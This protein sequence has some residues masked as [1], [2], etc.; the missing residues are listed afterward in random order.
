VKR[1]LVVL[2]LTAT[3]HAQPT[4]DPNEGW[5]TD[6]EMRNVERARL[7]ANRRV[8]ESMRGLEEFERARKQ[9]NLEFAESTRKMDEDFDRTRN[10]MFLVFGAVVIAML[11]AVA[12]SAGRRRRRRE[13]VSAIEPVI[14]RAS[15]EPAATGN[16]DVT[17]LRFGVDATPGKFVSSELE[18]LTKQLDAT[19]ED[20]RSKLVRE[21]G[22]ALR[23][24]RAGWIYGGAVNEPMRSLGEAK[25]VFAKH[26]DDARLRGESTG[27]A[28]IVVIT[29]V[30]VARGEL[31]TVD[32]IDAEHL[33]RALEAAAYRDAADIIDI[34]VVA[35]RCASAHELEAQYP[36]PHLVPLIVVGIDKTFCTYCG[37]PIPADLVGCPHC[38]APARK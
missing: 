16:F 12:I 36:R 4:W 30:V 33:R 5:V 10:H 8:E 27:G 9:R 32:S 15:I 2:L 35:A 7:D 24:V 11:G 6:P 31:L 29:V 20:G 34:G 37:G 3:A 28:G 21:I 14:E 22:L 38:G 13:Y 19:T 17:V 25:A 26:I 1:A 18:R 23:R